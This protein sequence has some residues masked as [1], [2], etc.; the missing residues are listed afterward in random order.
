MPVAA[1][2]TISPDTPAAQAGDGLT[3]SQSRSKHD[4]GGGSTVGYIGP[5]GGTQRVRMSISTRGGKKP[6]K[7]DLVRAGAKQG[8]KVKEVS[9]V[10]GYIRKYRTFN[11]RNARRN[12]SIHSGYTRLDADA[13]HVMPQE[14]RPFFAQR[15]INID[16]PKHMTWWYRPSHQKLA[17][18]YN[19]KWQKWISK[20]PNA[21]KKQVLKKARKMKAKYA[22]HYH[23]PG[24]PGC[25]KYDCLAAQTAPNKADG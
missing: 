7:A 2:P 18:K 1:Q 25:K 12:L 14:H 4:Y 6:T 19:R 24:S 20:H 21:S 10:Q 8:L 5:A 23:R 3:P 17:A 11:A 16:H 15:G 22:K 9:K 13:H